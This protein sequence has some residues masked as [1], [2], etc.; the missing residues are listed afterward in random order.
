MKY[1]ERHGGKAVI[2]EKSLLPDALEKL[3]KIEELECI[4]AIVC[5]QY[6]KYPDL[7]EDQEALGVHCSQCRLVGLFGALY[8]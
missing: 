3:A 1:T 8:C 5:D 7:S 4:P 6:C 2:R